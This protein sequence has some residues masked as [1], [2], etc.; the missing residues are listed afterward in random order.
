MN[1]VLNFLNRV[2]P[3]NTAVPMFL[4]DIKQ[5]PVYTQPEKL[6]STQE[7]V[8]ILVNSNLKDLFICSRVPFTVEINA[9]FVVDL[10]RLSSPNDITCDD[11][12]VWKWGGSRKRWIL[13]DEEGFVSFLKDKEASKTAI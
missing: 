11:M 13:V 7:C 5:L 2:K 12:G 4:H 1:C 9:T 8:A 10:N 6:L 3:Q